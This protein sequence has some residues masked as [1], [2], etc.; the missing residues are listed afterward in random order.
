M[1]KN[2]FLRSVIARVL[3]A[4]QAWSLVYEN[5]R[6]HRF[7]LA[8]QLPD[9]LVYLDFEARPD[10]EVFGQGVGWTRDRQ[11]LACVLEPSSNPVF[12]A[13]D[14]RLARLR[15]LDHPRDFEH[16]E[17]AIPTAALVRPISGFRL[18]QATHDSIREQML[19][20]IEDYALPYLCLMLKFRHGMEVTPEQL[21]SGEV[22]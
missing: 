3:D 7:V 15:Q 2:D 1:T 19:K 12:K 6:R 21:G 13:R 16:E 4:H 22:G 17:L 9:V 14:G 8:R 5:G 20:E 10:N 11:S 18:S